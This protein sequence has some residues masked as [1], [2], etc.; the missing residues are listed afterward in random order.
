MTRDDLVWGSA[1]DD[2]FEDPVIDRAQ[3]FIDAD[4]VQESLIFERGVL[5]TYVDTGADVSRGR[6]IGGEDDWIY[7]PRLEGDAQSAEAVAEQSGC[8]IALTIKGALVGE[9]W[10]GNCLLDLERFNHTSGKGWC[11]GGEGCD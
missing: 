1:S 7:E 11:K 3:L 2:G 9:F 8:R 5:T 10:I 6:E 4:E